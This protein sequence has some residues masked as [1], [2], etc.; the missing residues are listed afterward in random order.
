[1]FDDLQYLETWAFLLLRPFQP[2]FR[3]IEFSVDAFF[4]LLISG[5]W[6]HF[7]GSFIAEQCDSGMFHIFPDTLQTARQRLECTLTWP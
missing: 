2:E 5:S 1:V 6:S 4:G 7:N 3:H